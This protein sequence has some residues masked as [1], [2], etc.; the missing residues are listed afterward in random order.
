MEILL[1]AMVM[2]S[3]VTKWVQDGRTDREYARKGM[4]SPRYQERLARLEKAGRPN[5]R[6]AASERGPLRAY[7]SE[8]YA[9]AV[10]D[11]AERHRARRSVREPFDPTAPTWRQR[12]AAGVLAEVAD[13]KRKAG[14]S[15]PQV[16]PVTE[17][18]VSEPARVEYEPGTVTYDERGQQVPLGEQVAEA[19]ERAQRTDPDFYDRED[20]NAGWFDP[21]HLT[22]DPDEDMLVRTGG[23]PYL[24]G[25][26]LRGGLLERAY[27]C[28]NNR[29]P[30]SGDH[31]YCRQHAASIR[32]DRGRG[33][34]VAPAG[35]VDDHQ[36]I[37]PIPATGGTTMTGEAVNYETT[38]A[39]I[40]DAEQRVG[41]IAERLDGAD[42]AVAELRADAEQVAA[43]MSALRLDD[44]STAGV[45]AALESL[46]PETFADIYARLDAARAGLAAA[47]DNVISTY[48]DA[49]ATVAVTGVDEAFLATA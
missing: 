40:D 42:A 27:L 19:R 7:L 36:P 44:A 3:V 1:I 6:S 34:Y 23:C 4:V 18:A 48:G 24:V 21:A 9:D 10:E 41:T 11:L 14:W 28:A 45:H 46:T 35:D 13:Y 5:T 15:Q 25:P 12:F 32:D 43:G 39:A 26:S 47:R 37:E 2:S 49:A 22:G 38:I 31:P 20:D 16:E 30:N 17:P 8:L 29:S 33:G